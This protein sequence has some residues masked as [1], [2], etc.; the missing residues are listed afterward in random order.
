MNI[1]GLEFCVLANASV[2]KRS[3]VRARTA[4]G[5]EIRG[6]PGTM[7]RTRA[8]LTSP[9][10][11]KNTRV[12]ICSCVFLL[13]ACSDF[14]GRKPPKRKPVHPISTPTPSGHT[15][16]GFQYTGP[17]QTFLG[18]QTFP[19]ID[20]SSYFFSKYKKAHVCSYFVCV[21]LKKGQEFGGRRPMAGGT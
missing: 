19:G 14:L 12:F 7:A 13:F 5:V 16:P 4:S 3:R 18:V 17:I 9:P 2:G 10:P 20:V 15:Y 6:P 11:F 8:C 1:G 21:F